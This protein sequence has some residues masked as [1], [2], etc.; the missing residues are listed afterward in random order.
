M[1]AGVTVEKPETVTIDADVEIGMDTV[2]EP[3]VQILGN[4]KIGENCRMR[5]DAEKSTDIFACFGASAP[6][7]LGSDEA[8]SA[9]TR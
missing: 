6:L 4:S 9:N 5:L 2:I 3:F 7:G 1:L 8:M